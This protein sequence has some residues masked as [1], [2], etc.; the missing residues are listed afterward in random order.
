MKMDRELLGRIEDWM[1]AHREAM[2]Q[3]ILRL[4]RII[5]V[6]EP[7]SA[8]PPYGQACR[9]VLEEMLRIGKE[10]GFQGKNYEYRCGSLW[11]HGG[12]ES[13]GES[14]GIWGHLD[15]VPLGDH[16][17]FPPEKPFE[18]DG[19][20]VGRGSQDNKGPAVASLYAIQCLEE[21]G[22][23]LRHPL[24]LFFGCDE[25]RGMSDVEY[26]AS[27][28]PCPRLSIVADCGFPVCYGEKGILETNLI[29]QEPFGEEILSFRGGIA[30]NMVPDYAEIRLRKT[31]RVSAGI[32]N[33]PGELK[34]EEEEDSYLISAQGISSHT[35][36][37]EG[38]RSAVARLVRGLLYADI[39]EDE[40]VQK[41]FFLAEAGQDFYGRGLKIG[42]QD[43]ISGRLTCVESMCGM[44][45]QRRLWMHFNIRYP[46]QAD[47]E[48]I[49]ETISS[50]AE[51]H[52]FFQKLVRNSGPNYFP[53]EHP[54][55]QR[56]TDVYN[57]LTGDQREPFVMGGGTYARKLPRALAFGPSLPGKG[58]D[59]PMFLPGHGGGHE[60]DEGLRLDSLLEAMKIFCMGLLAVDELDL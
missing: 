10:H 19:Y 42:C 16:W 11:L 28:Y 56:L 49:L 54:A 37:P 52:G 1:Q 20:I 36:F 24:R 12:E 4:V 39:L 8:V 13:A 9:D 46:V 18:K 53:R 23:R 40:A 22:V 6:S 25:E 3:D 51:A 58:N 44:D 38:G 45:E 31:E 47:S 57:V 2:V 14:I 7:E 32:R 59:H 5:S 30:S 21:L 43:E 17:R 50:V 35:A 48:K 15:V 55:V 27:R 34:T 26:Y 33:L 29:S 60:P 41:F